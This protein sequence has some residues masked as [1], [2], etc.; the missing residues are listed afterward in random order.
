MKRKRPLLSCRECADF[1]CE[2]TCGELPAVERKEFER[3]LAACPPC[4]V[5]LA[6]YEKTVAL[7]KPALCSEEA[8]KGPAMPEALVRAIL[9]A[10]GKSPKPKAKSVVKKKP[11]RRT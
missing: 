5:Y 2:Y 1:L 8:A 6:T 3:H 7:E 4:V 9:A 11:K 10:R